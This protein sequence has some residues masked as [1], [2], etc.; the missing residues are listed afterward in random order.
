MVAFLRAQY[1]QKINDIQEIG[2]AMIAAADAGLSLSRET[3]ERQARLDLHA[4]EMRVR[5]LEETVIPYVGTA[6]PTGRIV[7]QQLRL[8]AAEHA[9]HR[10]YRTEWQPEGR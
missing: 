10:D 9:G 7:S 3:A 1:A 2:N 8:L 4:A 5:F 6:G